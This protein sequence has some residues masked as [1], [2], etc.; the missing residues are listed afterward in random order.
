MI[1]INPSFLLYAVILLMFFLPH[2][3][4]WAGEW[5]FTPRVALSALYTDNVN[6]VSSAPDHEIIWSV[7]PS[8]QLSGEGQR[9]R[10][11]VDYSLNATSYAE[12]TN[13]DTAVH[14]FSGMSSAELISESVFLDVNA[15]Y[16]RALV[17]PSSSIAIRP[18]GRD[19]G[20]SDVFS[21]SI[22]PYIVLGGGYGQRYQGR[23]AYQRDTTTYS[24]SSG[25]GGVVDAWMFNLN[26]K[27]GERLGWRLS[28]ADRGTRFE[29]NV[30]TRVSTASL[31]ATLPLVRRLSFV[32]DA[33]Y[34][35]GEYDFGV[36]RQTTKGEW[37]QLGGE[38]QPRRLVFVRVVV[39]ERA[40]GRSYEAIINLTRRYT[41]WNLSYTTTLRDSLN[42][43]PEYSGVD[44]AE[45]DSGSSI[46]GLVTAVNDLLVV[47]RMVARFSYNRGRST[48]GLSSFYEKQESLT[49]PSVASSQ[50]ITFN[51]QMLLSSR[52]SAG[53]D[54]SKLEQKFFNIDGKGRIES[55]RVSLSR[56]FGRGLLT[57]VFYEYSR[58]KPLN[59]TS[60]Y[61]ENV[62][63]VVLT[64]S[65]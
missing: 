56:S 36:L 44:S 24:G 29:N 9:I 8:A 35:V 40:F 21:A 2:K 33:G 27:P 47:K 16:Q 4:V 10:A 15:S 5:D 46:N 1:L 25:F 12:K 50:G 17:D 28:Y 20:D 13:N 51:H 39:G 62:V 34:Q 49:V 55:I 53:V 38:W 43:A 30:D 11:M 60:G 26:S 32:A 22:R 54:I 48:G 58:Q 45:Q 18:Y 52:T 31:G 23:L 61:N 19:A 42:N 41:G 3:N 6:A 37:W 64:Y 7:M 14:R 63:S 57:N 59:N 65:F